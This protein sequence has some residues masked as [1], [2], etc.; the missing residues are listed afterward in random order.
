MTSAWK[1]RG[2]FCHMSFFLRF[3]VKLIFLLTME[4]EGQISFWG[5]DTIYEWSLIVVPNILQIE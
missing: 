2:G 4:E 5:A 1:R 3:K